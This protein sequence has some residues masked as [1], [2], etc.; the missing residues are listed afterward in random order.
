M[1]SFLPSLKL[2]GFLVFEIRTK[3]RVM[4]KLL[5]DRGLVERE[6]SLRKG[7]FPNCFVIFL[8]EKFSLLLEHLFLPGKFSRLL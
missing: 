1:H 6:G 7:W 5:R 3:R 8:S 4:E 2:E